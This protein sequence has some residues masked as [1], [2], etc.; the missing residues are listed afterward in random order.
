MDWGGGVCDWSGRGVLG[1]GGACV[2]RQIGRL[3]YRTGKT[4]RRQ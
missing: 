3:E 1:V 4:T 2:D